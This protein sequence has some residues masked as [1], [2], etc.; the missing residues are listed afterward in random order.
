MP[1]K[2][3]TA[4]FLFVRSSYC[5]MPTTQLGHRIHVTILIA[6]RPLK[7]HS[8]DPAGA[9]EPACPTPQVPSSACGSV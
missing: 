5:Q 3:G 9:A 2:T 6:L 4:S 1:A 7:V 8:P